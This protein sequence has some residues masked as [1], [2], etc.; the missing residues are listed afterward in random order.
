MRTEPERNMRTCF[1]GPADRRT[2]L[3]GNMRTEPERDTQAKLEGNMR[4][5]PERNMRT[6]LKGI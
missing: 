1:E 4:T 6:E 5:E 2:E 3:G